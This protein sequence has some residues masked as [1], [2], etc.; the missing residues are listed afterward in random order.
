MTSPRRSSARTPRSRP[1]PPLGPILEFM[2][3]LWALDHGLLKTSKAM[4][5]RFGVTGLQRLVLRIVGKQGRVSAG[6]LAATLYVHPSTLTGVLRRLTE[7]GAL[8][9]TV[10]PGDGRR[11][12][13]SLTPRGR[14]LNRLQAGTVEAAVRALLAR[15]PPDALETTARVLSRLVQ[16]LA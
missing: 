15:T 16:S 5:R 1:A 7:R 3:L 12:L 2:R 6:E 14:R 8:T 10:D 4:N 9:R 11:A 13:F